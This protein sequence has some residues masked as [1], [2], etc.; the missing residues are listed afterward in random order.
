MEPEGCPDEIKVFS[1]V[2]SIGA[3]LYRT[4]P[5][6]HINSSIHRGGVEG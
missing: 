1:D 5:H 4:H 2:D 6:S 3:N